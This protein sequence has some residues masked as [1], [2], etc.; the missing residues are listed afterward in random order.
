[1]SQGAN[2]V[3]K[4]LAV[5]KDG[6]IMLVD[7]GLNEASDLG[8]DIAAKLDKN[9]GSENSGKY[10]A[11]SSTGEIQ[12]VSLADSA[13]LAGKLDISQGLDK[14]GYFLVV[15]DQGNVAAVQKSF[16]SS[17]DFSNALAGKLNKTPGVTH[18]GKYM[19]VDT[20]GN[21]VPV[22]KDLASTDY[23]DGIVVVS[24]T[25]PT[26]P[27]NKLWINPTSEG[28]IAVPTVEELNA[29]LSVKLDSNL[30]AQNQGKFL[31]VGQG[32]AVQAVT[33]EAWQASR[34]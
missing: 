15:N 22:Q 1:M 30:G 5:G 9:L 4:Y 24:T 28:N 17:S 27:Q 8:D 12:P 19:M 32:G 6:N 26:E 3:G 2:A 13:D 34:Y 16:V 11:I 7:L 20:N 29:G 33:M 31:V 10:L 23:A 18:S 14:V 21:I 25:T